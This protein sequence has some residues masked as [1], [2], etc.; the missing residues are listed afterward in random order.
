MEAVDKFMSGKWKG[1]CTTLRICVS[2]SLEDTRVQDEI[3]KQR[4][5]LKLAKVILQTAGVQMLSEDL[6]AHPDLVDDFF[7][8][9]WAEKFC[10]AD[11]ASRLSGRLL[12]ND[13][14]LRLRE[15]LR[16]HYQAYFRLI[17][18]GPTLASSALANKT[19]LL[20]LSDRYIEP[21]VLE[22]EN[23]D[24]WVRAIALTKIDPPVLG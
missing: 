15:A 11:A 1:K 5:R 16:D 23:I 21:D 20:P 17:D 18:P 22:G 19:K 3:D 24:L 8:R 14:I 7:G 2:V 9:V 12:T 13:E 10:G 4:H 6:K